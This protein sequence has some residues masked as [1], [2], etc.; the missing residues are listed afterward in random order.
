MGAFDDLIPPK[1]KPADGGINPRLFDAFQETLANPAPAAAG[2]F[3]DLVPSAPARG[4]IAPGTTIPVRPED[5]KVGRISTDRAGQPRRWMGDHWGIDDA[6]RDSTVG[7]FTKGLG[8]DFLQGLQ[9]VPVSLAD[10]IGWV[11]GGGESLITPEGRAEVQ[12][13]TDYLENLKP[14]SYRAEQAVPIV[15]RGEDGRVSGLGLPTSESVAGA[16]SQS[17]PQI[18]T[19][20]AAGG[21]L[22]EAAARF[23]PNSP[24]LAAALGY[25]SANAALVTP[26][27]AEDVRLH[28][29]AEGATS[30]QA[31]VFCLSRAK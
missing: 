8:V 13:A 9:R 2:A 7:E 1:S 4:S 22:R 20:L 19:F 11:F 31:E 28:A 10:S 27:G 5:R 29:L 30:D 12:Q 17:A 6:A 21:G 14:A 23:L 3:D 25:G 15:K 24:R 26:G 16:I 18:P